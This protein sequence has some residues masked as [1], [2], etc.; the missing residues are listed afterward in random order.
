MPPLTSEESHQRFIEL[1]EK[2]DLP[3]DVIWH[4]ENFY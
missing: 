2:Y 4:T 3:A 1:A